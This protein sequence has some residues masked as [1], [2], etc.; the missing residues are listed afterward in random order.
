M[1]NTKHYVAVIVLIILATIGLYLLFSNMFRLPTAASA[2]AGPIDIM[3]RAHFWVISFLFGLIMVIMLYSAFAFR[4]QPGDE[5]DAPHIHGSSTL[6]IAWTVIPTLTVIGFGVWAVGVLNGLITPKANE[7]TIAVN[8]R[9]WSWS[10]QYPEQNNIRSS[11]LKLSVN[12]PVLLEM[13]A[14]DVIHSFWVPEFRVKQDL[15]PGQTT[16]LRFTPTQV[17]TYKVRCA[18]ICGTGHAGMAAIVEVMSP[19]AFQEFLDNPP[20]DPEDPILT[21]AERGAI[22]ASNDYFAC[23]GCHSIDGSRLVGPSWLGLYGREEE[24]QDGTTVTVDEDYIHNSI[25][26]PNS[27]IVAGF[28]GGQMPVNYEEQFAMQESTLGA[29][30]DAI[31]ENDIVIIEDIIAYIETLEE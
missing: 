21:E 8:A 14:Q 15:V 27:Q 31:T 9:Q 1:K 3:F 29:N 10:F 11:E 18:E 13:N 22:W 6:E 4:R 19:E 30:S 20:P 28:S 25:I 26:N 7:M 24:L 2:E 17:G 12:Q 5:T 16:H 23:A